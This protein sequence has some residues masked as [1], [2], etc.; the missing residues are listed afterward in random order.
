MRYSYVNNIKV[1]PA[2]GLSGICPCCGSE[3]I[4]K[5]G[6]YRVHYWAHK[7]KHQC[8]PWWENESEWHRSWKGHFPVECQ[9]IVFVNNQTNEKHIADV[10]S[11]TKIVIEIQ[12]YPIDDEEARVREAYYGNMI[13]IVN[14]CKNDFDPIN[15]NLSVYGPHTENPFLRKIKWAGRGKLLAKWSNSTKPVYFDFGTDLVWELLEYDINTK[16]CLVKAQPKKE[17]ILSLGGRCT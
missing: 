15:F 9:E 5:C 16:R 11:P 12:S 10:Y 6:N 8:D 17:F 1:E 3:T 14:G 7:N 13:W 4:A 2:K